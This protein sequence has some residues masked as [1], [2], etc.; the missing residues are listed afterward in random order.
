MQ[1]L[2]WAKREVFAGFV[3]CCTDV[4]RLYT[5]WMLGSTWRLQM[6]GSWDGRLLARLQSQ[7]KKR[8]SE[9]A[10]EQ[11]NAAFAL[12]CTDARGLLH[13]Q[14]R[15]PIGARLEQRKVS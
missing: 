12:Q 1:S 14:D 9:P 15:G 11:T 8:A 5:D 6:V 7:H 13:R 4:V 10:Q 2:V 3:S